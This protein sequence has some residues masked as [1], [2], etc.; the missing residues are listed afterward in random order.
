MKQTRLHFPGQSADLYT[1]LSAVSL[2]GADMWVG[3]D[4][5]QGIVGLQMVLDWP[6]A[7][8]RRIGAPKGWRS[9]FRVERMPC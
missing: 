5:G 9:I 7:I 3:A 2:V 6:V 8:Y 4:E 1:Q